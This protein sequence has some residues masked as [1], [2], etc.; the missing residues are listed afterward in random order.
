M[1]SVLDEVRQY[2]LTTLGDVYDL[3]FIVVLPEVIVQKDYARLVSGIRVVFQHSFEKIFSSDH[4]RISVI[5]Q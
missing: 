2:T 1:A 4:P 5:P 3:S